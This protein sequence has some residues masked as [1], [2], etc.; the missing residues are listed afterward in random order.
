M[1]SALGANPEVFGQIF[2]KNDLRTL[3]TLFPKPF[4]KSGLLVIA[5]FG[6]F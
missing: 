6:G 1:M 5:N 4:R 3:R 2:V